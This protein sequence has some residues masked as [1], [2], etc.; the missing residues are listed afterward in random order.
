MTGRGRVKRRL[1]L[2]RF[3][4]S[5]PSTRCDSRND[6]TRILSRDGVSR[7]VRHHQGAVRRSQNPFIKDPEPIA[8]VGLEMPLK[9]ERNHERHREILRGYEHDHRHGG[10]LTQIS[11]C[12]IF[13]QQSA[14]HLMFSAYCGR[15]LR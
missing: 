10:N 9:I 7:V 13:F 4:A 11:I 15:R 6:E 5:A 12:Q 14:Q 8:Q 2:A 3:S 1:G